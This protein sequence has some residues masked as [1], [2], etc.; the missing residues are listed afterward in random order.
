MFVP[1]R[2]IFEKGTLDYEIGKRV[3]DTFHEKEGIEIIEAA[4]NKVKSII[5]TDSLSETYQTG[6]QTLVLS[7]KKSSAFQ[8]CKPS[9]DYMLPLVSGCMGQ[10]EYCY[11]HTQLGDKPFVRVN[12]NLEDIYA[13]AISYM[14]ASP[15]KV[16]SFEGSATSDPLCV[17]P[18]TNALAE[19]I[20]FFAKEPRGCFR[21]VTKFSDVDSLLDLDH[22]GKTEIRFSINTELVRSSYEHYTATI[23]ARILAASKVM[24]AGYPVGFLIA[25]VFLYDNWQ[26][27]YEGVLKELKEA[28]PEVYPYPLFFEVITHRFT[29]RAKE[30]IG[31]L[32]PESTL[33]MDEE[34]RVYKR[35]QFGYGKFTYAKEDMREVK[36]FFQEKIKAYFP[37]SE[38]KYIV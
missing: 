35:G 34:E 19:T 14:E 5:T 38:V 33:P 4:A 18:Y 31:N 9:A 3:Y 32:F 15:D 17:E 28:L 21:F 16:T 23:S 26:E 20:R 27:E 13:K 7:K 25:P 22:N 24:K 37:E 30:L 10:C 8:T 2:I 36:A 1:K 29:P 11:L 6:K 12:V